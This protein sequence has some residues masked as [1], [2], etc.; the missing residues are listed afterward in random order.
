MV[1]VHWTFLCVFFY[2]Y[3]HHAQACSDAA[4]VGGLQQQLISVKQRLFAEEK[5]STDLEV[6]CREL[7]AK[8]VTNSQKF[9]PLSQDGASEDAK[10]LSSTTTA[11]ECAA[12]RRQVAVLTRQ[13][14]ELEDAN[15]KLALAKTSL[16]VS[17]NASA[18]GAQT[19]RERTHNL[20]RPPSCTANSDNLDLSPYDNSRHLKR[21]QQV[22][23]S[24]AVPGSQLRVQT[25]A[26]SVISATQ[27]KPTGSTNPS[28][29]LPANRVASTVATVPREGKNSEMRSN[30]VPSRDCPKIRPSSIIQSRWDVE[31]LPPSAAANRSLQPNP[32]KRREFTRHESLDRSVRLFWQQHQLYTSRYAKIS[33]TR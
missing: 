23:L 12:L 11:G 21:P 22:V 29:K 31:C 1:P 30:P 18:G 10:R 8:I 9:S 5:R 7:V 14:H 2:M 4:M 15:T 13:V 20:R 16:V 26:F 3:R 28:Q 24:A 6:Q 25:P 33:E 17:S 19:H 32:E 27:P